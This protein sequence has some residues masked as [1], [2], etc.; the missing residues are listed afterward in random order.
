MR[1]QTILQYNC[2]PG[3]DCPAVHRADDG[4]ILIQGYMVLEVDKMSSNIKIPSNEEI[5][6]LPMEFFLQILKEIDPSKI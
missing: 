4:R 6:E 5:V 2:F 1:V 3:K